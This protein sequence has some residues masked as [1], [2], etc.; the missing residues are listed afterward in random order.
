MR[1]EQSNEILFSITTEDVQSEAI[2]KLGRKLN[3]EE[4]KIAKKG[5]ENALMFNID[6]VYKTIFF[7]MI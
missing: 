1:I 7:E 6:T 3:E 4:I 5:L 2:E